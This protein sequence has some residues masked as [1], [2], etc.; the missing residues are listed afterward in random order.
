MPPRNRVDEPGRVERA[1][2]LRESEIRLYVVDVLAPPLVVDDPGEDAGMALELLDH[3]REL[4]LE[5]RLLRRAD[6]E[7]LA[8][9]GRPE[10]GPGFRVPVR[11]HGG[12]VL[13]DQETD[14]VAGFV[15]ES[16]FDFDLQR[17]R[18]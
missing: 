10:L 11:G 1:Y 2:K 14:G 4:A 6:L 15:E 18:G 17:E 9:A 12:H 8:V 16:G 5:F 13:D 3:E 7:W